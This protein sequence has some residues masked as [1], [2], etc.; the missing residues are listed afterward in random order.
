MSDKQYTQPDLKDGQWS[1][2]ELNARNAAQQAEANRIA[3]ASW[4]ISPT[5]TARQIEILDGE[6]RVEKKGE[7]DAIGA[8]KSLHT[9]QPRGYSSGESKGE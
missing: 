7:R 3:V 9:S 5:P 2:D 1:V 6:N 4:D 8:P